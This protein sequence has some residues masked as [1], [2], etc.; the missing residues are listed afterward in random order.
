MRYIT[1]FLIHIFRL[2]IDT[3]ENHA[4]KKNSELHNVRS[5]CGGRG[6]D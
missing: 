4:P 2:A 6:T 1:K 3:W 5:Q